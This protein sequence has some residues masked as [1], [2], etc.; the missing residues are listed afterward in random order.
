MGECS[1]EFTTHRRLG[2]KQTVLGG[3]A[4]IDPATLVSETA[5][6]PPASWPVLQR[7][8]AAGSPRL[9]GPT[10]AASCRQSTAAGAYSGSKLPAVHGCRAS[11]GSKL[12]TGHDES[13]RGLLRHG[14]ERDG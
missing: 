2:A 4:G 3:L 14:G 11:G 10:A 8:Q 1:K 6:P 9:A 7:Q 5:L 13:A 12:P